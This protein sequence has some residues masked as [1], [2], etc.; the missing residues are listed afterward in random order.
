MIGKIHG[1]QS[2]RLIKHSRQ[3]AGQMNGDNNRRQNG[4]KQHHDLNDIG[5]DDRFHAPQYV[6]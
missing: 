4:P 1:P 6:I 2:S 3:A 5:P